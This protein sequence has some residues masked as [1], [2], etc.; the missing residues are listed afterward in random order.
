M[1]DGEGGIARTYCT[2]LCRKVAGLG[3]KDRVRS[4]PY[5]TLLFILAGF[6]S[7]LV[8]TTILAPPSDSIALDN[9]N[10][11]RGVKQ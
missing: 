10:K 11:K 5:L 1:A 3:K 6:K 2:V 4:L 7:L 9:N 8:V